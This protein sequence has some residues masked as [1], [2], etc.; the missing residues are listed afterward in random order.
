[1]RS[2]RLAAA[3]ESA[4]TASPVKLELV[5][6]NT[7]TAP[8]TP[9]GCIEFESYSSLG[10]RGFAQARVPAARPREPS[11]LI[12]VAPPTGR[13]A[14]SPCRRPGGAGEGLRASPSRAPRLQG[15]FHRAATKN[16]K[17]LTQIHIFYS[18]FPAPSPVLR[19][20]SVRWGVGKMTGNFVGRNE[21]CRDGLEAS[22]AASPA[23]GRT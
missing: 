5:C 15:G 10:R 3:A 23:L 4:Q 9:D 11:T 18:S 2:M 20:A 6:R 12:P 19:A 17:T 13:V 21:G 16:A 8:I 22:G 1:M 7:S 14:P